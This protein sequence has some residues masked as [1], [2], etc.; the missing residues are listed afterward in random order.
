MQA[1]GV[2]EVVVAGDVGS[3]LQV[4]CSSGDLVEAGQPVAE[5]G[6]GADHA[7]ALGHQVAHRPLQRPRELLAAAGEKLVDVPTGD[8]DRGAIPDLDVELC[9]TARGL[10][11]DD[12]PEDDALASELPPRRLAPCTPANHTATAATKKIKTSGT[13]PSPENTLP[14]LPQPS[15]G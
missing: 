8:V 2:G 13:N 7:G 4:A 9:R 1:E 5:S 3:H 12:P 10:G 15:A 6:L 11:A 14:V